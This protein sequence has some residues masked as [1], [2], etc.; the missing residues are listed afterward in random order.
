MPAFFHYLKHISMNFK[1]K[2]Q[3]QKLFSDL[4][5]GERLN[6][7]FQRKVTK[8]LPP[9]NKQFLD[10]VAT[11]VQHQQY[12]EEY[13]QIDQTTGKY[14]EFGAGWTLTVPMAMG[15]MG[16]DVHCIDIRRLL[17][18]H[19]VQDSM[20]KFI[21][22]REQLDLPCIKKWPKMGELKGLQERLREGFGLR[23]FAPL[24]AR[25]TGFDSGKFDFMSSTFTMEHIPKKDIKPILQ[26]CY[27]LLNDGGVLSMSIDYQDHWSYFD[28]SISV[29]NYL[30]YSANEWSKLNPSLHYQNR[31]RH[32][33]YMSIIYETDFEVVKEEPWMPSDTD[34]DVLSNL[35]LHEDYH[36]YALTDLGMRACEIVLRKPGKLSV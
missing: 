9:S 18:P 4:P 33:D 29:Y 21:R 11:A 13:N 6:Y 14:Y 2:C 32:S 35:E 3:L 31:L 7:Y 22:N 5:Y 24:D 25:D 15:V 36:N 27:R 17:F 19:L 8:S 34:Y 16:Y 26:E 30:T 1:Y 10:K 23:Y 12:F 20:Q 28:K